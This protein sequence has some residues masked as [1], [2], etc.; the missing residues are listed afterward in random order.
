MSEHDDDALWRSV[1]DNPAPGLTDVDSLETIVHKLAPYV[2]YRHEIVSEGQ[3]ADSRC[4]R[5]SL[6]S[7][8]VKDAI[9]VL[10]N[11][12]ISRD[13]KGGPQVSSTLMK[14]TMCEYGDSCG[15]TIHITCCVHALCE[16]V[17]TLICF[18]YKR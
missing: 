16:D 18:Y 11:K 7:E 9:T 6:R 2:D 5:E 14:E 13:T 1:T 15:N 10:T 3:G 17:A 4:H 8:T 12:R